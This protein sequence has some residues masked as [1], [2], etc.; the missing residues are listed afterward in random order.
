I[1]RLSDAHAPPG[2]R[3]YFDT[4]ARE[5]PERTAERI[6][7][8]LRLHPPIVVWGFDFAEAAPDRELLAE[9]ARR[10]R[11]A[12]TVT[13]MIGP[14]GPGDRWSE[15]V[16]ATVDWW[17]GSICRDLDRIVCVDLSTYRDEPDAVSPAVASA[18]A[19]GLVLL[20]SQRAAT[21]V[22]R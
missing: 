11:S 1:A 21:R 3:L 8:T 13:V 9:M 2:A 17:K 19:D 4:T 14:G 16:A 22:R 7:D 15:D 6:G 18:I 5:P 10:S 12:A 20:E